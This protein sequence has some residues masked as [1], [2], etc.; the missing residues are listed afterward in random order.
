MKKSILKEVEL[1]GTLRWIGSCAEHYYYILVV[2]PASEGQLRAH[3]TQTDARALFGVV[4]TL[5]LT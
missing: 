1:T 4:P 5:I 2:T 3:S